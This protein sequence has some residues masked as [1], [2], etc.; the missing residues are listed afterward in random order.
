MTLR[1]GTALRQVF[2]ET[3][4][5]LAERDSRILILDGDV[6]SSTGAAVF[7]AAYPRR[8]IQ[9]GPAE[10]NM[11]A[12]AAGMATVGFQPYV[13][14]FACFAVARALDSIR[15]LVA[16]PRLDVKIIGGYAGL[17]TGMTG[18]TH[19]MFNDIAIMRS[20]PH[21]VVLAPA[22]ENEARQ[23]ITAIASIS[24]P[25]YLQITREQSPVLFGSDYTFRLGAAV[26]VRDGTDA[27]LV[28]TGVQTTRA[29]EAAEIL[30]RRGI[31]VG[32]LHMPTVK[33]LD[34]EALIAAARTSGYIITVEEQSILGGLGG[35]VAELLSDKH[36][37][38]VKR[39][40]IRDC[41]GES[42]ANEQLLDK[43]R[44]SGRIMADDI[45][46]LLREPS[47]HK[48]SPQSG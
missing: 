5:E 4:V 3:M 39:L 26:I 2:G 38:R 42:G 44:L 20:I 25:V 43:Y 27:T 31:Q 30:A 34:G 12:M 33:P 23:A 22:D 7:E 10:Q 41:F 9:T 29:F 18:K 47:D 35:A 17:L 19:Q 14:T 21:M 15:V 45:L 1:M 13:T 46:A 37:V 8:Y 40:G 36:P 11:M 28:S 16:Q 48:P 6:G 24:D 32:V